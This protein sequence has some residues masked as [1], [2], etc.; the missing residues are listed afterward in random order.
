MKDFPRFKALFLFGTRPEAIKLAPV[1]C[2]FQADPHYETKIGVTG[3]HR[4]ML[5]QVTDFFGIKPEIDLDLMTPNQSLPTLAGKAITGC[6]DIFA[7]LQPDIVFVQGDT[8]TAFAAGFAAFLQ[9]IPVAHVEAGLRSYRKDAPFPEEMNR[10]LI[11][12]VADLHFAPLESNRQQLAAEGI[13]DNVFVVGNTVVD[14]LQL[15]LKL[16]QD[17][18]EEEFLRRFAQ[19]RFDRRI[20]LVTAHRRESFG[21]PLERICTALRSLATSDPS[22][23]IVYPVHLNPHVRDT[24]FRMLDG[25]NNVR[26]L[27]PLGYPE[28]IWLMSK[29]SLIITDSGGVQEEAPTVGVPVLVVRD[30]TERGE[31]V[32]AGCSRLVGSDVNRILHEARAA[33]AGGLV[34]LEKRA[35]PYGD[36][37]A[38]QR[39]L[40]HTTQ[41][42]RATKT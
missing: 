13:R 38:A 39:I 2:A 7:R 11:S 34:P 4:Q 32:A 6:A 22:L 37:Q 35:N 14:A 21:A 15:G 25:L 40:V 30:V 18:G 9:R 33:L 12:D 1:I 31:G 23:E 5:D 42:L 28:F 36:G 26:L 8:T 27:D 3:Q 29:S 17:T 16:I 10:V 24:V 19:I 20:I 41:F